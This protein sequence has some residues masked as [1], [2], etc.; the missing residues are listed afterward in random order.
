ML[1]YF[2]RVFSFLFREPVVCVSAFLVCVLFVCLVHGVCVV[3]ACFP[4]RFYELVA[5]VSAIVV[6]VLCM[7]RVGFVCHVFGIFIFFS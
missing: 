3:F 7:C 1:V 4:M 6:C 2:W 5:C